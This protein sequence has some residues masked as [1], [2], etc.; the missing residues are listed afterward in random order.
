LNVSSSIA[1]V[2]NTD[3]VGT[4]TGVSTTGTGV[5]TNANPQQGPTQVRISGGSVLDNTTAFLMNNPGFNSGN[6]GQANVSIF[7]HLTGGTSTSINTD[8]AGNATLISGTGASCANSN[9]TSA[10][11]YSFNGSF[12]QQ[13]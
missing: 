12:N 13:N 2:I 9:C 1:D 4:T 10:G 11:D 6:S 7:L 8:I 5:N 3:I